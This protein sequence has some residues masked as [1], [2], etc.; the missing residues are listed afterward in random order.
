M[1]FVEKANTKPQRKIEYRGTQRL[2]IGQTYE[3]TRQSKKGY[4]VSV[5]FKCTSFS[6]NRGNMIQVTDVKPSESN[7]H[8]VLMNANYVSFITNRFFINGNL[9]FQFHVT[10]DVHQV[11]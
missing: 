11:Q 9:A 4:N 6:E 3:A 1:H 8:N 2:T 10:F 7:Y 5:H